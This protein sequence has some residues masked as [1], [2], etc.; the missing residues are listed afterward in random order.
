M[1]VGAEQA[2]L[3]LEQP[4]PSNSGHRLAPAA[5]ASK[6][7]QRTAHHDAHGDAICGDN[8]NLFVLTP[9]L[10]SPRRA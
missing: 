3:G 9:R 1:S 4:R 6:P 2:G 5:V 7:D 10:A 8:S